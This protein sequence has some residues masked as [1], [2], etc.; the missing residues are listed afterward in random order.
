[1]FFHAGPEHQLSGRDISRS[2]AVLFM[3][4]VEILYGPV[5]GFF[6]SCREETAGNFSVPAV[7]SYALAAFAAP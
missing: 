3:I 1:M 7:V 2:S 5:V 4:P 6:A